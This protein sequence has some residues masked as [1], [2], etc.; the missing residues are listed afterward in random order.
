M[1]TL[2]NDLGLETTQQSPGGFP[3]HARI[4]DR[5]ALLQGKGIAQRL[6]AGVDVAFEHGTDDFPAS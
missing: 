6:P 5:N 3:F 2:S 4:R 1:L